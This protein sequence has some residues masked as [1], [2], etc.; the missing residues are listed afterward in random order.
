MKNKILLFIIAIVAFSSCTRID[1]GHVGLKINMAGSE[2][3]VSGVTEVTGW[4]FYLP[5][6]SQ[7]VEFPVFTQ[8]A[9]FDPF[10]VTAKGGSIFTVD[11]TLNYSPNR[12][13]VPEIYQQYRKPLDQIQ[14]TIIRNIVYDA[15]RLTA[16]KFSPDSLVNNRD[17]FEN[18][19]EAYLTNA[20]TK[21][22]FKF[23]RITSNL[24]PPPSLQAMIDA[25]NTAVQT[26]LTAQNKVKTAEAEAN[27]AV[28]VA[29]GQA[30]AKKIEAD[31]IY[32]YNQKVQQS[33]T[34][35]LVE[36]MRIEAWRAGGSQVPTTILSSGTQMIYSPK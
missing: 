31:G 26:G 6:A 8:T 1:A 25:K 3:G 22:G 34:P 28:A 20:L 13:S 16:N 17:Q 23:E 2:K 11:P 9:D 24:T 12:A 10:T 32:Y 15:Y 18:M 29:Q 36:K 14:V 21:D 33:L 4:V 7:I 27:I 35:L 5:W 19:A 30:N